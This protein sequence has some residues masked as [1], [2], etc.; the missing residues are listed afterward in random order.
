MS[1][2]FSSRGDY[3]DHLKEMYNKKKI[4]AKAVWG[5]GKRTVRG[6]FGKRM[7]LFE[8]LVESVMAYGVEV[9]RWAEREELERIKVDYLR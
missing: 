7:M 8:Y 5:L 3:K 2:T 1:F 6:D 9:W 4:A